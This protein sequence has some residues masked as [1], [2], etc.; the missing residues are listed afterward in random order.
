MGF[1]DSGHM[2]FSTYANNDFNHNDYNTLTKELEDPGVI[3]CSSITRN[4]TIFF[5]NSS[6]LLVTKQVM[7]KLKN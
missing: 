3:D 6:F 7:A 4:S 5:S 2:T 1:I